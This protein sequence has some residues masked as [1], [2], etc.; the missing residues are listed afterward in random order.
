MGELLNKS[1]IYKILNI[2]NNKFYIGSAVDLYKRWIKHKRYANGN[3]HH[4]VTFQRAWNKYGE[5]SFK[6]IV[7]EYVEN[8]EN[9]EKREQIYLDWFKSYDPN[10]GYNILKI[11]NS[12][13]GLKRSDQAKENMRQAQL[14]SKQSQET[15]ELRAFLNSKPEKWPCPERSR[16]K[17]DNCKDIRNKL[18]FERR[19]AKAIKEGRFRERREIYCRGKITKHDTR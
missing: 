17:C 3:Y 13:L 15:I 18:S 9:L 4:S 2:I 11:V 6:F 7:L 12:P 8:K 5:Q 14:G 19:E 16:C 10:I 1:G